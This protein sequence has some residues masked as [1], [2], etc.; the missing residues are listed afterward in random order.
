MPVTVQTVEYRS[1]KPGDEERIIPFLREC[2]YSPD[3]RSWNWINRRCPHGE[4]LVELGLMEGR[5]VGHYSVLP[6]PLDVRGVRVS[7]G[8][9]IHA[10]VHPQFRGLALLQGLMGRIVERCRENRTRFIYAFPNDQIWLVYQKLFHWQSLG[11]LDVLELS[12]ADWTD[13]ERAPSGISVQDPVFF[14]ERYEDFLRSLGSQGAQISVLKDRSYL[15]WRYADHPKV[16]Y[17]LLEA[18]GN[19]TEILG[20]LILKRYEKLGKHYGHLVEFGVRPENTPVGVRLVRQ[21]LAELS[22]PPVDV[23][24]CWIS[25]HD[26]LYPVLRQMGFDVGNSQAPVGYRWVDPV[27][28]PETFELKDWQIRMGDSDAF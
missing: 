25:Q 12:L 16:S 10:A 20:F 23:V 1:S 26:P 14:D 9:A 22:H 17:R 8:L 13:R 6:R 21:A 2:G 15:N 11:N 19:G 3:D 24:S 18:R 7:S 27:R 4:T 5:I 28:P